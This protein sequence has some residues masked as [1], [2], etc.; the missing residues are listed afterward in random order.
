MPLL[1]PLLPLKRST[2]L[3]RPCPTPP[4]MSALMSTCLASRTKL[5]RH[6]RCCRTP[7][8]TFAWLAGLS[9]TLGD[10]N[11][12]TSAW[13]AEN[14][15]ERNAESNT[16]STARTAD[17]VR[18]MEVPLPERRVEHLIHRS[19]IV[20]QGSDITDEVRQLSARPDF[21]T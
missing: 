18:S 6:D 8:E 15:V 2:R 5:R 1:P 20:G 4:P 16:D 9:A 14:N 13:N 12:A 10:W 17:R 19:E 11:V 3:S 21:R 7:S